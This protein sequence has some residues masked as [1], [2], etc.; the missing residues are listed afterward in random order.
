[1]ADEGLSEISKEEIYQSV[2]INNNNVP[3]DKNTV[4]SSGAESPKSNTVIESWLERCAA[5][6]SRNLRSNATKSQC[7]SPEANPRSPTSPT[8]GLRSQKFSFGY[9]LPGRFKSLSESDKG[10]TF[11]FRSRALDSSS[12]SSDIFQ[13][14]VCVK[15][16][17]KA[18]SSGEEFPGGDGTADSL[19][20]ESMTMKESKPQGEDGL[21][22]AS[23][24]LWN[25]IKKKKRN[26]DIM[27]ER[28]VEESGTK[29]EEKEQMICFL[30]FFCLNIFS[31]FWKFSF[32]FQT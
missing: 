32:N 11:G 13:P 25:S 6:R 15:I 18:K 26:F 1:M 20:P 2:N 8:S 17:D 5:L 7:S 24:N 30:F 12:T 9:V 28:D 4:I 22:C 31:R 21:E 27:V 23:G 19:E 10:D 3:L 14:E 16:L 29:N